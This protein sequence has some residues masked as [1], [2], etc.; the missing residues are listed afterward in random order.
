MTLVYPEHPKI[1]GA[2]IKALVAMAT[3]S[4]VFLHFYVNQFFIS[5]PSGRITVLG[6]T[7]LPTEKKRT[8]LS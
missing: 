1:L 8:G 2:R 6:T 5:S 3:W 7:R 4:P